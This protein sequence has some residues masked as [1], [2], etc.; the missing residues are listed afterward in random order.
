M[1]NPLEGHKSEIILMANYSK[2]S[3]ISKIL[4]PLLIVLTS[5]SIY[6]LGGVLLIW[7]V[8]ASEF[9]GCG[10]RILNWFVDRGS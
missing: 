10:L 5:I 6:A 7:G 1:E 2:L 9:L 3:P 8:S 4:A